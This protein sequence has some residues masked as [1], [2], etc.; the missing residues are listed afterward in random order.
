MR[1][2]TKTIK[3]EVGARDIRSDDAGTWRR[4]D[5]S[6]YRYDFDDLVQDEHGWWGHPDEI[7][8]PAPTRGHGFSSENPLVDL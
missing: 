8:A 1:E 6:G 3:W 4:S 7:D 5:Y 2:N